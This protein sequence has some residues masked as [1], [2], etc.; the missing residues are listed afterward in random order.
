MQ[1]LAQAL[2]LIV[3]GLWCTWAERPFVLEDHTMKQPS[4]PGMS[5]LDY[6]AVLA[7]DKE[8]RRQRPRLVVE[9]DDRS[10]DRADRQARDAF[11]DQVLYAASYPILHIG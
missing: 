11:V 2:A 9:L 7:R 1:Y 6:D 5:A 3:L 8:L 4:L 10:H